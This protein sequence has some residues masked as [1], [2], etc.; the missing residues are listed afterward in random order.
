[1][2]LCLYPVRSEL[3][4]QLKGANIAAQQ[5]SFN[6]AM[7]KAK[8]SVEWIFGE[9]V[10]YFVF[11]DFKKNL[12]IGLSAVGKMY[13]VCAMLHNAHACLYKNTTYLYLHVDPSTF[14]EYVN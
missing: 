5:I 3:M 10:N 9:I 6:K 7:S 8:I 14:E 2:H 4:G 1:M 13:R 11:L 12:K